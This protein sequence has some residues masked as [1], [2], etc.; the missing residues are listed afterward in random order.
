VQRQGFQTE[1][2]VKFRRQA[3]LGFGKSAV[4]ALFTV[5]L[6]MSG[7]NYQVTKSPTENGVSAQALNSFSALSANIFEPKCAQCHAGSG[8]AGGVDLSSY[9]AIMSHSGLIKVG[10]PSTS[11]IYTEVASG[12]MPDSGPA[13]A[14]AEIKAIQDWIV[15]G[16]P[17][18]SFVTSVPTTGSV[19]IELPA[20]VTTPAPRPTPVTTLPSGVSY[21][22]IQQKIFNLSCTRCH[23]GSRP[24]KGI[25]LTSYVSLMA[26]AALVVPGS[27]SMSRVYTEIASGSMPPRGALVDAKLTA[28][29]KAW[30]T[31]GAK[32]D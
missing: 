29:L 24:A 2:E 17:N 21:V 32:N 25:D 12:D 14:E 9:A 3:R 4:T 1:V 19:P 11:L 22:D 30:I 5:I 20:P 15:A 26:N 13:L 6:V 16:A 23:S 28:E 27:P 7:C 10:D 18:G 31:Q 8:A